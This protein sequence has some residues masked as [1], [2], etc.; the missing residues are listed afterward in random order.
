MA[1]T[2]ELQRYR[3]IL[4]MQLMLS[5]MVALSLILIGMYYL[6]VAKK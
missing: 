3:R 1:S 5:L 4:R 2:D 6:L